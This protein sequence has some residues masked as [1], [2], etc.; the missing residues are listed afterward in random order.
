METVQPYRKAYLLN[1]LKRLSIWNPTRL[2]RINKKKG[3]KKI[4]Y[5]NPSLYLRACSKKKHSQRF[6]KFR[7]I[8]VISKRYNVSTGILK[9]AR[10]YRKTSPDVL[11]LYLQKI[12]L[13][14]FQA[15]Y[16][17]LNP[18]YRVNVKTLSYLY[19]CKYSHRLRRKVIK[20]TRYKL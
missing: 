11:K 14:L 4:L 1:A 6:R 12:F 9:K 20:L 7:V 18:F 17:M 3:L 8:R 13:R 5:R 16:L 10:K 19:L 2:S 15:R